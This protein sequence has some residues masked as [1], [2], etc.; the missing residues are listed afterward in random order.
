MIDLFRIAKNILADYIYDPDHVKSVPSN[1][2]KTERGW[3]D[4][5][6]A[7]PKSFYKENIGSLSPYA[8]SFVEPF[9][10]SRDE[11]VLSN[12]F[13]SD[14]KNSQNINVL[15]F[16]FSENYN[17][18][19]WMFSKVKGKISNRTNRAWDRI[20][21]LITHY[22]SV[23]HRGKLAG[24]LSRL[25]GLSMGNGGE[26]WRMNKYGFKEPTNE[27]VKNVRLYQKSEQELLL[28][29]GL[30]DRG[31]FVTI[32]RNTTHPPVRG[33][34]EGG[35]IESWSLSPHIK[36]SQK[37]GKSYLI[38]TIVPLS[39]VVSSFVGRGGSWIHSDEYEVL[40]ESSFLTNVRIISTEN[41][42]VESENRFNEIR[43]NYKNINEVVESANKRNFVNSIKL[44]NLSDISNPTTEDLMKLRKMSTEYREMTQTELII[45]FKTLTKEGY[46]DEEEGEVKDN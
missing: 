35:F 22:T 12:S 13:A 45:L 15:M 28:H 8:M 6:G 20:D 32:Y 5:K 34:Y 31:G 40:V 33:V 36:T 16:N 29:T 27:M 46:F 38:S 30:V 10:D 3:S 43:D 37:K 41:I 11:V 2:H 26:D 18:R 23:C 17:I 19:N 7:K 42:P 4:N 25:I 39:K 14:Y 9:V 44:E 24:S 1:F 21:D